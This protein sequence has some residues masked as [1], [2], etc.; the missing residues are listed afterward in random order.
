MDISFARGQ[1]HAFALTLRLKRRQQ[2]KRHPD[3]TSR[4]LCAAADTQIQKKLC[5]DTDTATDTNTDTDT[6]ATT[7]TMLIRRDHTR[8][9]PKLIVIAFGKQLVN[10]ATKMHTYCMCLPITYT[11]TH[12]KFSTWTEQM[13]RHL[14]VD[15][16][17][18]SVCVC[19]CVWFLFAHLLHVFEG[20]Y[21]GT[22]IWINIKIRYK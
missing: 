3:S 14:N 15:R 8:W 22:C 11:I 10:S 21:S 16:I 1:L 5:T 17:H 18:L 12:S 4:L 7:A 19:A 13:I 6:M 2:T 9:G 20:F